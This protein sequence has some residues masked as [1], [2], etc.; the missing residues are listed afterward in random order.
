MNEAES[1]PQPTLLCV[2]EVSLREEEYKL[3]TKWVIPIKETSY[4]ARVLRKEVGKW[5]Q[6]V[7]HSQEK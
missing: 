5:K 2:D 1:N 4:P 7:E 6:G 3:R